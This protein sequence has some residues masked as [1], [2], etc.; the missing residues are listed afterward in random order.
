MTNGENLAKRSLG[1]KV[2]DGFKKCPIKEKKHDDTNYL[3]L[4]DGD[5]VFN[6]D[7]SDDDDN[8]GRY[9]KFHDDSELIGSHG[10]FDD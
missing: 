7:M 6:S 4:K 1:K 10:E 8:D 3:D 9:S 2:F 5:Y